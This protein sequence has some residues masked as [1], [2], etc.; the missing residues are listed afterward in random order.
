MKNLIQSVIN[1]VK[2]FFQCWNKPAEGKYIT[3]KELVAY[4]VGG[5]GVYFIGAINA[6]VTLSASCLLLGSVYS[7][8]PTAFATILLFNTI[9]SI[10]IQPL[11]SWL[12]DNIHTK[13]GKI[14]PWILWLSIPSAA[15]FTSFAFLP[16]E[17]MSNNQLTITVGV[18]YV[19]TFFIFNFFLGM[20]GQLPQVMTPNT[21]ERSVVYS[22][23]SIVYSLAPTIT[24]AI[25][26][27][28]ANLFDKKLFDINYYRTIF[29]I[30][31]VLGA[32]MSL[33]AYF[34]TKER[35]IV[36]KNFNSNIKFW[37]G[38]KMICKNKYVWVLN[39]G[40]IFIFA[41][42][43]MVGCVTWMYTYMLQNNVIYSLLTL[44]VGTASL[45]G[46]LL[47]P[48]L[49]NKIGKRN[50]TIMS[51]ICIMVSSAILIIFNNSVAI[52][53]ICL[54]ISYFG[55]AI[56]IITLPA[57]NGDMLDHLQWQTG[58]RLEGMTGNISILTSLIAIG[59]NYVIP[60]VNEYFG[61]ID[62]YDVLYDSAIRIPMF[63]VLA[64]IATIGSFLHT[65]TYL[66]WDL[67]EKRHAQIMEELKERAKKEN[68]EAGF[69]DASIL[70]SGENLEAAELH[71]ELLQEMAAP[72]VQD[73]EIKTEVG[74]NE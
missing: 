36:P 32:A 27:L 44:V 34:G 62:N 25:F 24:G 4:S 55:M 11:K 50:T 48:I 38:I 42:N 63:R 23:S 73:T 22:V 26:P 21:E 18:L 71:P 47:A 68:E 64:I 31:A 1:L 72:Q 3:S 60:Y 7:I 58:K 10:V 13:E 30:V 39:L 19:I 56:Q 49:S 46:M 17:S 43:A 20:Y 65:L 74:G 67:T 5:M 35:V 66:P 57:M 16:Y 59:T 2:G 14:K 61:L 54:Y 40:S 45:F 37:D 33:I 8:K 29:P 12:I 41:R 28:I 51:D 52:M 15:L 70:S 53:A 6:L 69:A 9:F